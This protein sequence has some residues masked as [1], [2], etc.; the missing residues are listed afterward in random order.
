MKKVKLILIQVL[1]L[2]CSILVRRASPTYA[3]GIFVANA[4]CINIWLSC[5]VFLLSS[6]FY[7]LNQIIITATQAVVI[8]VALLIHNRIGRAVNKW[9]MCLY[10]LLSLIFYFVYS[11][12]VGVVE[13]LIYCGSSIIFS[14][15]CMY[16]FRAVFVRGLRY[17]LGTDEL[18]FLATVCVAISQSFADIKV[19]NVAIIDIVAPFGILFLLFTYSPLSSF[20]FASSL[21][22]GVALNSGQ[23]SSIAIYCV[24][25]LVSVGFYK[26]SKYLS[27]LALL[28]SLL[29]LVF[30]FDVYGSTHYLVLLPTFLGCVV[31]CVFPNSLLNKA[32]DCFGKCAE[33]YSPEPIINR[34]RNN[35]SRR[36]YELADVFY[37]MQLTYKSL[38]KRALSPEK[39]T[40][41]ISKDVSEGICKDCPE[42][43]RCWRNNIDKTEQAFCELVTAGLDKGK[44]TL[45][46]IP[47][48]LASNCMRLNTLLSAINK[49]VLVYKEYYQTEQNNANSKLLLGEQLGGVSTI[50]KDLSQSCRKNLQFD[51]EKE[52]L[53]MQELT[54]CHCL[55][56]EA[57]VWEE[58]G[59][60]LVTLTIARQ[61]A[62]KDIITTIITKLASRKMFIEHIESM[63]NSNWD[64]L[65]L[66]ES[67]KYNVTFGFSFVTKQGS[68]ISGDTH[69]FIRLN[70]DK[71]LLALSDG[72]GSGK[73]AQNTSNIAIS[74]VE[75]FYKAN[76]DSD[77]ILTCVNHLLASANEETFTALDICVID[78]TSGF[79][80]FIK[81]GSPNSVTRCGEEVQFIVGG[82][83]PLG[84]L[85]QIKPACTKKVLKCGDL[86]LIYSDGFADSFADK[87][88][89]AYL[90][91]QSNVT[92][93][94]IIADELLNK[95]IYYN[96][97]QPKDDIT[98]IVARLVA[99]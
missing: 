51:R 24:F 1:L 47:N 23:I 81:L 8:V 26:L 98:V 29:V 46:D 31:F 96:S 58:D 68:D 12:D 56:K 39:A 71:F 7:G 17:R 43:S 3:Y 89:I 99:C 55:V 83:L 28:L 60:L 57:V 65:F 74:L 80:D 97:N 27:A 50:L 86:I 53:A 19:G 94:Q 88:E 70:N 10:M 37:E 32:K 16:V 4:Y 91:Q 34:L 30:F 2:G 87:N 75:N 45:L 11:S 66:K 25:A 5:V 49:E 69:S 92:N 14:Y 78:L 82:S 79:T 62:K 13:R 18:I 72:M 21:G 20:C 67:P 85:S 35:I 77:C 63:P 22:L 44:A 95:A 6:V 59:K 36:L 42:R 84:V 15:V 54:F 38:T 48:L 33:H 90:L 76:F 93:P 40:V 64:I 73:E 52:K 41:A 61:D 9:L